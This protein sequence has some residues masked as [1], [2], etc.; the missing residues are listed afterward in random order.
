M[1]TLLDSPVSGSGSRE[2]FFSE[3]RV[4]LELEHPNVVKLIGI[5]E[6][7]PVMIVS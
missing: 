2:E 4:M 5:C 6:G 3:A 7:P 1:K